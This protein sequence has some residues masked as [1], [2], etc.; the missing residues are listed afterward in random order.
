MFE[1]VVVLGAGVGG[2]AAT[3]AAAQRGAQLRLFDGGVGASCLNPGAIDDRPWDEVARSLE[4]LGQG[5]MAGPLPEAVRVFVEDF[6]GWKLPHTGEHLVRLCTVSGR[7]RVARGADRSLLDLSRLPRGARVLV[8]R[9]GRPEW[10]ADLL[11][12]GL[13]HDDFARSYGVRFD[14]VDAELTKHTREV[15]VSPADLA[16][17]HDDP[18]RRGW[19]VARLREMLRR[20]GAADAIL[21]GPWLGIDQAQ[22]GAV[23]EAMGLPVGEALD[24]VGTVAGLRYESSRARMLSRL[25]VPIEPAMATRV[26]REGGEVVVGLDD[27]ERVVTDAAVVAIGG[28]VGGGVIYDPPERDADVGIA[29]AGR[30]PFRLSLDLTDAVLQARARPLRVVGSMRGPSLDEAAWPIDADPGLLE[31]VGLRCDNLT[32]GLQIFAAGDIVADK[33]RTVLQAVYLGLLAGA[34][35]AGEPGAIAS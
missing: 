6:A 35:A 5:A 31:A 13:N 25:G 22:A 9:V 15:R 26:R 18:E 29:S 1:R 14:A 2:L 34:A 27:G 17:A 11:A 7:V 20:S 10:N 8:P 21:L 23:T 3:W 16:V 30:A 32:V 4:V 19:L 33:P 12:K 28:L 24:Q